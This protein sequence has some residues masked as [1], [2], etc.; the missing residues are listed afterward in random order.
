M[1]DEEYSKFSKRLFIQFPSLAEWLTKNSPAPLETQKI[2][3]ETLR[4]CAFDECLFVLERWQN[5]SLTP[6]AAY[7]R[8]QVAVTIASVVNTSRMKESAKEEQR[9][10]LESRKTQRSGAVGKMTGSVLDSEMV[11]AY[12]RLKPEYAR[13]QR[14]E[15]GVSEYR[16]IEEKTFVELL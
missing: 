3:R 6:F 9:R 2:W 16:A 12:E 15:I 8:D 5:G 13:L 10:Y 1:T 4:N 11:K 14:G 7:E